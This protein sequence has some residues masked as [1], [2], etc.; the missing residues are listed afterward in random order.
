M[1]IR[2]CV[3]TFPSG[4]GLGIRVVGGKEIPG[5]QGEIGAY[6]AN[7]IPGGVA[8]GKVVEGKRRLEKEGGMFANPEIQHSP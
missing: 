1:L 5:S 3:F 4:N 7:I 2:I 8:T 6:V